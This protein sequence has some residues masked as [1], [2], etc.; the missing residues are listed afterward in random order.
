MSGLG[1]D[2]ANAVE[3]FS[4]STTYL[5]CLAALDSVRESVPDE[6]LLRNLV[7]FNIRMITNTLHDYLSEDIAEYEKAYGKVALDDEIQRMHDV[8]SEPLY[9]LSHALEVNDR[10][11]IIAALDHL[12][13]VSDI[14]LDN[15]VFQL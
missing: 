5:E 3:Q 7:H 14:F 8:F 12:A 1:N 6:V 10:E 15:P 9:S 11:R 2:F 13:S 4:N